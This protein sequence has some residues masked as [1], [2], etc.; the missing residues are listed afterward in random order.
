MILNPDCIRDIL[1]YIESKTDS[2]IDS[3]EFEDL[4]TSLNSYD[5]NTLHYHVN[6]ISK[7]N[8]VDNVLYADDAPLYI[9]D[10]SPAGH[11]FLANIRSNTNW[12]K[13]KEVAKKVG[14]FSL[15]TL[16]DISVNLISQ[17]VQN[18]FH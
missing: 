17:L 12:N 7:S 4:V 8:L 2:H 18:Q 16:K 5:E 10:L 6:Q 3:I 1:M 14:S 13:T 15:D 11:E 9:S